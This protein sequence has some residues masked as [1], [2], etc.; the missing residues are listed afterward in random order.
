MTSELV[1][2]FSLADWKNG[3][4]F[5]QIHFAPIGKPVI[6]IAELKN[7]ITEQTAF[8]QQEFDPSVHLT[9]GDMVFSWSGNPETSIDVFWYDL[10]DGWLNQHIF[11]VT[12]KPHVNKY[13]LYYLLKF[14]KPR[15]TAI[16]SNKQTTGLGHVTLKDLKELMV[17]LPDAKTQRAIGMYLYSIDAKA[18]INKQLND[19]LAA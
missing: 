9:K 5:G 15:F 4:A 17:M 16:A 10:E 3:L 6:K 7:G 13:Y 2:L 12:P 8:T 1:P 18:Y 11:K 14:L 19:N